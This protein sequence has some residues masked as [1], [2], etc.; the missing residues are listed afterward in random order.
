[1]K[2][3]IRTQLWNNGWLLGSSITVSSLD[4]V[5]P[6]SSALDRASCISFGE[7]SRLWIS[8]SSALFLISLMFCF[9]IPSYF[10][11]I[12]SNSC[13]SISLYTLW[14][15][16]DSSASLASFRASSLPDV[17]AVSSSAVDESPTTSCFP[18]SRSMTL[19]R[20]KI[21]N[22]EWTLWVLSLEVV[23]YLWCSSRNN[24]DV[25]ISACLS[26]MLLHIRAKSSLAAF[27]S[28]FSLS[29]SLFSFRIATPTPPGTIS[30]CFLFVPLLSRVAV[31]D[32]VY[33]STW[34][35]PTM[36]SCSKYIEAFNRD[37]MHTIDH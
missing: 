21:N 36:I 9:S 13:N 12:F 33:V 28:P 10:L 5:V 16:R 24:P 3:N 31:Y 25:R 35:I 2:F 1:M 14:F 4:H 37:G 17:R 7:S 34:L 20:I 11:N 29:E 19:L 26:V 18:S 30:E 15:R 32:N 6:D 23:T 27:M 8:I 22:H